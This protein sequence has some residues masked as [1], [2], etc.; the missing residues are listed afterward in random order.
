MYFH[1]P[2][3]V[4]TYLYCFDIFLVTF[5]FAVRYYN[6]I[7]TFLFIPIDLTCPEKIMSAVSYNYIVLQMLLLAT[8]FPATETADVEPNDDIVTVSHTYW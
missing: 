7:Y 3:S 2:V 6:I 8:F 5:S 4:V 1:W